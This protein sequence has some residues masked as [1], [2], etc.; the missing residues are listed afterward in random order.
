[1]SGKNEKKLTYQQRQSLKF[2][3]Q[4][5]PPFI[6]KMKKQL[7]FRETKIEDKFKPE[8]DPS[9]ALDDDDILNMREEE[10]PQ[11]VVLDPIKDISS[12]QL[13]KEIAKAKEEDDRKKIDEG[14]IVFRKPEKRGADTK[15]KDGEGKKVPRKTDEDV[16]TSRR[17]LSFDDEE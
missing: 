12:E 2:I 6:T 9:L 10:R 13:S 8:D 1:M 3:Q 4:E 5:D 15:A 17:L 16:S 14:K 7:G 11:I